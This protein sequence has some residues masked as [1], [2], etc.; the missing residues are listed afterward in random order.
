M[1]LSYQTCIPVINSFTHFN[2]SNVILLTP[3][4]IGDWK[5]LQ[6]T[7]VLMKNQVKAFK[8]LS[9]RSIDNLSTNMSF[10]TVE[11]DILNFSFETT[12]IDT[13]NSSFEINENFELKGNI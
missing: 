3:D 5:R 7:L 4:T 6:R 12:E 13:L 10:E 11:E 9:D 2:S 1:P 8:T